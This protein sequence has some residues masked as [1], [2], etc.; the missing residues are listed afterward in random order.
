MHKI[1]GTLNKINYVINEKEELVSILTYECKKYLVKF[2][3]EYLLKY[4]LISLRL[5]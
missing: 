1:I 5:E 2:S 3:K 4:M